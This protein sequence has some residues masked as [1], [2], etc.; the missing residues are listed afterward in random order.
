MLPMIVH[1][2]FV[3]IVTGYAFWKQHYKLQHV[4]APELSLIFC[5]CGIMSAYL[6]F[7]AN[8][9]GF[10]KMEEGGCTNHA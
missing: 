4:P 9:G 3:L 6:N 1:E 2:V 7:L 10:G 8:N 5:L